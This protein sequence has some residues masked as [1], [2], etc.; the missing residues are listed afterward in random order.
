MK[1]NNFRKK[2]LWGLLTLFTL[3][4]SAFAPKPPSEQAPPREGQFI[5][6][7]SLVET[8]TGKTVY[9][10]NENSIIP[11]SSYHSQVPLNV[12][13]ELNEDSSNSVWTQWDSQTPRIDNDSYYWVFANSNEAHAALSEGNHTL[14]VKVYERADGTGAIIDSKKL[15]YYVRN[16]EGSDPSPGPGPGPTPDPN[17][18]SNPPTDPQ[19]DPEPPTNPNPPTPP[20]PPTPPE[21]CDGSYPYSAFSLLN[22]RLGFGANA[23]GGNPKNIYRVTTLAN[24]GKGSLRDA[25]E[26]SKDYWIV[27]DVNGTIKLDSKVEVKSNKTVDGRG[28][29]ITIDGGEM[30]LKHV[31]NIIFSDLKFTFPAG[32]RK[33]ETNQ[34]L[35][36]VRGSGDMDPKDYTSRDLWFNH[37]ELTRGNDG[38]IDLRGAT[39][40]TIS[41][42]YVHHHEKAFLMGKNHESKPSPGMRVTMHHNFFEWISRRGPKFGYG[43]L[44]FFNNYHKN[45][46]EYGVVS[47]DGAQTLSQ[48][49]IFEARPGD[50]CGGGCPDPNTPDGKS[51]W[52]IKKEAI[53]LRENA[54]GESDGYVKSSGDL[55]INGARI[56]ENM[57]SNV[58]NRSDFYQA[59]P[60]PANAALM[61]T[62]MEKTGPRTNYCGN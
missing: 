20:T 34:D 57:P 2:S 49:N 45:F 51:G 40:V 48:N 23:K 50:Y 61:Q 11:I 55:L 18:P 24:S 33:K 44:D 4:V 54:G 56:V 47:H 1:I 35:I 53:T 52:E 19:P 3:Q 29:T 7:I 21:D 41:W 36:T 32:Y 39:G 59:T 12:R 43:F 22:E 9:P 38:A 26:S 13:V 37:L 30:Y 17:P 27:F 42:S 15:L 14:D 46:V 28:R 60:S 62:L 8:S 16:V 5:K 25:L 58:F 6:T 10:M 31:K